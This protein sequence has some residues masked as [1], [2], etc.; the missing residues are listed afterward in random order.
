VG[1]RVCSQE[2]DVDVLRIVEKIRQIEQISDIC[3]K[4]TIV[5]V[6]DTTSMEKRCK[7]AGV[8]TCITKPLSRHLVDEIVEKMHEARCMCDLMHSCLWHDA[9]MCATA[10]PPSCDEDSD[11]TY[12]SCTGF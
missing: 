2:E 7:E 4:L 5:A 1:L 8:D 12:M 6:S 9:C 11:T 3:P 10:H